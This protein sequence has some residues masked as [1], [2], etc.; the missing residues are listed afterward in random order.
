VQLLW[1]THEI[2]ICEQHSGSISVGRI[3]QYLG[4]FYDADLAAGR[5]NR[6]TAAEWIQALW[7]K[8]AR[9]KLSYQNIILGGWDGSTYLVNEVSFLCLEA[10]RKLRMDPLVARDFLDVFSAMEVALADSALVR[11]AVDTSILNRVS[12]WDA[13]I[14]A[15]AR[16]ANCETLWTE[17]LN[18]GQIIQGV[19]IENPFLKPSA[20]G[21]SMV[22]ESLAKRRS[23]R[24]K[25]EE[26][27]RV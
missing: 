22:R 21:P 12:F 20:S 24:E 23:R 17:D 25:R 11:E 1:L 3:D 6:E 19:R 26:L 16:R 13:L 18:Q 4:S 15:S 10:T 9:L 14:I 8:F 2:L 27:Y 5:L 7:L